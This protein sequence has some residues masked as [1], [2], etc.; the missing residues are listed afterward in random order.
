MNNIIENIKQKF[1]ITDINE[2][3]NEL[4]FISIS[5]SNLVQLVTYLKELE[6]F[7]HLVIISAV[8]YIE[9]NKFQLTYILHNY[10]Q[11][12]DVAIRT[13]IDRNKAEM[14]SIH[15]LWKQA[16]TYQREI[17]EMFGIDFPGSPKVDEPMILEGWTE[18]PPMRRDFD[19]LKYSNETY[20][21]RPGRT[22]KDPQEYMKKKLY[23]NAP[24]TKTDKEYKNEK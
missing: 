8:D 15:H 7:T 13:K 14:D 11:N 16:K 24:L 9:E 10:P 19:T 12:I 6:E 4:I 5:A 20:F 3:N 2:K 23:P 22:H 21:P 17:R 18:M 1:N